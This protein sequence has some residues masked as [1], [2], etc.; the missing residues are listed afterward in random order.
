MVYSQIIDGFLSFLFFFFLFLPS[1]VDLE[2]EENYSCELS[3]SPF[4]FLR[5]SQ[6]TLGTQIGL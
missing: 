1:P 2:E 5:V 3:S 6:G 4:Y